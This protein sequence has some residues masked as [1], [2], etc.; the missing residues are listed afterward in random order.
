M[1]RS[2]HESECPTCGRNH[3][4]SIFV[5]NDY[6]IKGTTDI[7]FGDAFFKVNLTKIRAIVKIRYH[8]EMLKMEEEE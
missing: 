1:G 4:S 8:T 7:H 3:F 5:V 6:E 2:R